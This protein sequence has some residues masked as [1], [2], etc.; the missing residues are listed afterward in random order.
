MARTQ[1][2]KLRDPQYRAE[3]ERSIAQADQELDERLANQLDEEQHNPQCRP[4]QPIGPR[5]WA[6]KPTSSPAAQATLDGES[7]PLPPPPRPP[8]PLAPSGSQLGLELDIPKTY[9]SPAWGGTVTEDTF[10]AVIDGQT[11]TARPIGGADD[12]MSDEEY[13]LAWGPD[14]APLDW[15]SWAEDRRRAILS[16]VRDGVDLDEAIT[17]TEV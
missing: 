8:A 10:A 14:G 3:L 12:W 16:L 6:S 1:A 13:E 9:H 5:P 7:V 17:E 4:V 11:V 15:S 2:S